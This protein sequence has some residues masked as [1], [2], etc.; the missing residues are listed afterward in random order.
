MIMTAVKDER[1][2]VTA[3][4]LVSDSEYWPRVTTKMEFSFVCNSDRHQESKVLSGKDLSCSLQ[5]LPRYRKT[6]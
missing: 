6:R 1:L 2:Y 3:I 4:K 5:F